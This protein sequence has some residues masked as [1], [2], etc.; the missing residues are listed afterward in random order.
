MDIT[1]PYRSHAH[2]KLRKAQ[3][4][5]G[6]AQGVHACCWADFCGMLMTHDVPRLFIPRILSPQGLDVSHLFEDH[7]KASETDLNSKYRKH[8]CHI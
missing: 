5:T 3:E 8:S 6:M 7:F 1:Y 2:I 4:S